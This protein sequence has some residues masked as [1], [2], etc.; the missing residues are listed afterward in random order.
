MRGSP[1]AVC[2]KSLSYKM[3]GAK[4]QKGPHASASKA[5]PAQCC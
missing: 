2:T 4:V 5:A 3:M 1:A